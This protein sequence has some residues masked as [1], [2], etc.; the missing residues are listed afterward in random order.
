MAS[1]VAQI[2]KINTLIDQRTEHLQQENKQLKGAL[3][4]KLSDHGILGESHAVREALKLVIMAAETPVTVFLNGESGTGKERFSQVVHLNSPRKDKLF[5]AINCSAIPEALLESEL[6]GYERGA[7]TGAANQK[8]GKMELANGGTLFLDEIGDLSLELQSKLLRVLENQVIQ[9]IGGV[10]DIPIDVRI[11]TATHKN[12]QEAV[13]QGLFR[14]DLFY[15]LNVFPVHLPPLRERDGDTRILARH[16][17]F[18]ANREFKRNKVLNNG[19]L[20]RLES[21]N[22]PGNIRQLENVIKR[23]VLITQDDKVTIHDIELILSQ[24]SA[25]GNHLEAGQSSMTLESMPFMSSSQLT[26]KS[27]HD[28]FRQADYAASGRAY[29]RVSVDEIDVIT[30]ALKRTSGNKTRAAT[31]LGMTPR[32]LRY[33]LEKLGIQV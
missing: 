17:L 22:W 25:I 12:L 13:N 26:P 23:A 5:L 9:R 24:E 10:Q 20:E 14:L 2:I 19:V 15:R 16:F 3:N 27:E 32:Q 6:F 21:Y 4:S 7:F 29:N 8:I 28:Q 33:R 31:V 30:E 11:I 18:A 1:F